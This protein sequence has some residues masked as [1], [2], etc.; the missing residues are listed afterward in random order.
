VKLVPETIALIFFPRATALKE[1][2]KPFANKVLLAIGVLMVF[3]CGILYFTA[4]PILLTLF[5]SQYAGSVMPFI[6][7]IPGIYFISLEVLLMNYF[8]A[9]QMPL[10]VVFTPLVGLLV[11]VVLNVMWLPK[12][13]INAAAW[14]SVISYT[15]MF[16]LLL[17]RYRVSE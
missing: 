4:E 3:M 12:Y 5:G 1:K 8:A 2:A 9:K 6:I 13:G 17:F 14:T 10:Y 11:N 7:L 15:L 16:L